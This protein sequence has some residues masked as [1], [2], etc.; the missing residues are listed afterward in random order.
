MIISL[1]GMSGTGKSFWSKQ[2]A[3]QCGFLRFCCDDLIEEQ[4]AH[5]LSARGISAVGSWMGFPFEERYADNEKLYQEIEEQVMRQ[6]L[7]RCRK[8]AS[9][10]RSVVIDT[11]GSVIYT[12]TEVFQNLTHLTTPIHL[13][14]TAEVQERLLQRYLSRPK[15][16]LWNGN[17][18][19][20]PEESGFDAIRRCYPTLLA[21]R[22]QHYEALAAAK[23]PP[24]V[25]LDHE[26]SPLALLACLEEK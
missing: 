12:S 20:L 6:V 21:S 16:V 22:E 26:L 15:P 2:L 17:F 13:Q 11:T 10:D 4:L 14:A 7:G 25:F 3:K 1:I 8:L 19:Q 24:S 23:V 9:G 5:R 18:N